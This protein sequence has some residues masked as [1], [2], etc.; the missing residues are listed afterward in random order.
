M[1]APIL[2]TGGA[3]YIGSVCV[4]SLIAQKHKVVVIDNLQSGHRKAVHPQCIF[5]KGNFGNSSLIRTI[6]A[7]YKI[8]SVIHFAAQTEVG[9]ANTHPHIYFKNNLV[10][11]ISLLNSLIK[12]KCTRIVFS[13]TAAVYGNSKFG[14]I[15]ES[16]EKNPLNSYGESKLMFENVIRHYS[17]AHGLKY[18]IFR[19]FNAAGASR[20]FGEHHQTETHLIPLVLQ[21]AQ[22][23]KESIKIFGNDYPTK[24]GTCIRDY[25]HVKDIAEAHILALSKFETMENMIFNLGNQTGAS[26]KD[27]IRSCKKITGKK[28]DFTVSSRRPGDPSSLIADAR[29]ARKKLNWGPKHSDL[30]TIIKSAWE[31]TSSH[32]DGYN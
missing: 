30:Q 5:V 14:L 20:N 21:V 27:V 8:S 2:V 1:S 29:A 13:S 25:V 10:N 15:S 9:K 18:F 24:D 7:K 28:I 23:K 3:G 22:K 4:E 17:S 19:Y 12:S 11:G 26:V 32:P 16:S 6:I 31:W